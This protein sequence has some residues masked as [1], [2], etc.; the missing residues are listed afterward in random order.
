MRPAYLDKVLGPSEWEL[1]SESS[2]DSHT[3]EDQEAQAEDQEAQAEDQEAQAED[4]EAQAEDQEAQ[5]EDRKA[6]RTLNRY[7]IPQVSWGKVWSKDLWENF[8]KNCPHFK[9]FADSVLHKAT[10]SELKA[11]AKQKSSGS[12]LPS[13]VLSA[14]FKLF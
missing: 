8:R 13:Q 10:L 7:R 6:R 1:S 11:L 14:N 5:A 9:N 4:Q 3:E 12:R 2:E